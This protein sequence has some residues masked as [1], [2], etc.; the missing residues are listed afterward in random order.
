MPLQYD[1]T[2]C[3]TV[4][5]HKAELIS[6]LQSYSDTDWQRQKEEKGM[7]SST[8]QKKKKLNYTRQLRSGEHMKGCLSWAI[9]NK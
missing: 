2:E 1:R 5:M 4:T 3:N 8:I 7:M 9:G 6:G